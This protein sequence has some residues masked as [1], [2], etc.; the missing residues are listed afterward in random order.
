M[1]AHYTELNEQQTRDLPRFK[2]AL[3]VK[4]TFLVHLLLWCGVF[5]YL[6]LGNYAGEHDAVP[7]KKPILIHLSNHCT[8]TQPN[9]IEAF[10]FAWYKVAM[11][12]ASASFVLFGFLYWIPMTYSL[13][14][15]SRR[16]VL[17]VLV[18]I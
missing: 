1:Y 16:S 7:P 11:G 5:A 15:K 2:L 6:Y 14:R 18:P 17:M 4:W 9:C 10:D 13:R 12:S 8:V 3:I